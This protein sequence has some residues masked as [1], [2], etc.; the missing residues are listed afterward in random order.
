MSYGYEMRSG[1]RSTYG[2]S[3]SQ[4]PRELLTKGKPNQVEKPVLKVKSN[5]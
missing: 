3:L 2:N 5:G 1:I 4:M